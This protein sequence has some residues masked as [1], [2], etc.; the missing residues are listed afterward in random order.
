MNKLFI[1]FAFTTMFFQVILGFDLIYSVI[2]FFADLPQFNN[3]MK[4]IFVLYAVSAILCFII[5][6][7]V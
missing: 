7:R 6:K 1:I 3:F 5:S 4:V 2:A